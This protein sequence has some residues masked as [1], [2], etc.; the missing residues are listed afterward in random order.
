MAERPTIPEGV[1]D[2]D[3]ADSYLEDILDEA[4]EGETQVPG[5]EPAPPDDTDGPPRDE[6]GRFTSDDLPVVPARPPEELQVQLEEAPAEGDPPEPTAGKEEAEAGLSDKEWDALPTLQYRAEGQGWEIPG[7]KV[8]EDG[9]FIPSEQVPAITRKIQQGHAHEGN[10]R[11]VLDTKSAEV[12]A[13]QVERDAAQAALNEISTKLEELIT[14]PEA[15]EAWV[16]DQRGNWDLLQAKAKAAAQDVELTSIREL[17]QRNEADAAEAAQLPVMQNRLGEFIVHFG[18]QA[19]FDQAAQ[20]TIYDRLSQPEYLDRIFPKGENGDRHENP[21]IVAAEIIYLAGLRGP[22]QPQTVAA[23][24]QAQ[25]APS[26]PAAKT[27]APPRRR[28]PPPVASS[29]KGGEAPGGA[30]EKPT[31]PK[32]KSTEEADKWAFSRGSQT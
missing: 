31:V 21:D 24:Q 30:E 1:T 32:F 10:F 9:L 17:N 3:S 25:V 20:Q 18:K 19:E 15:F 5:S 27:S 12:G 11:Q 4:P 8:Y 26:Q 23:Q 2:L 13:M 28:R 6:Q 7:S 22:V 14:K 16:T 29:K